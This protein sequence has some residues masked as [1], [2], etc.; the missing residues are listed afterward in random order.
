MKIIKRYIRSFIKNDLKTRMGFIGG[1]RQVGK[2]TLA[3]S[4]L[5]NGNEKHPAYLNWDFLPNRKSL[6]Q[7]ELP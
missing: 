4:L 6:L 1:P 3:L 7:G 2:T 5:A